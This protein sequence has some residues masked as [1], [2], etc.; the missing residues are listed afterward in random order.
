MEIR[1][2]LSALTI[3]FSP[4]TYT[5]KYLPRTGQKTGGE[6][7]DV[8]HQYRGLRLRQTRGGGQISFSS[9]G[10]L[11]RIFRFVIP[12]ENS[13]SIGTPETTHPFILTLP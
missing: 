6:C 5:R 2:F 8:L 7:N 12:T 9:D 13:F 3:S 4:L 1:V 10:L 11:T